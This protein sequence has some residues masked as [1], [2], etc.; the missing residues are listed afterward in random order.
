ML[1]GEERKD[2]E[3][4]QGLSWAMERL[5]VG[6]AQSREREVQVFEQLD[7]KTDSI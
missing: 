2:R 1:R 6:F 7:K 3:K 4:E 5:I